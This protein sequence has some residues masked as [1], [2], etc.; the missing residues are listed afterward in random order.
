M[1]F[2]CKMFKIVRHN[3]PGAHFTQKEPTLTCATFNR[4][5]HL[6]SIAPYLFCHSTCFSF[7]KIVL[8]LINLKSDVLS[9]R[10]VR[11]STLWLSA[12]CLYLVNPRLKR[13]VQAAE[14]PTP[15][16][17]LA[18][19]TASAHARATHSYPTRTVPQL[20]QTIVP[21][22]TEHVRPTTC[23]KHIRLKTMK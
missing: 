21:K 13:I 11:L 20:R 8:I 15:K 18:P 12:K 9:G 17:T 16:L 4:F 23:K 10:R 22:I 1:P 14:M 5:V 7:G 6:L 19:H 2:F 3:F